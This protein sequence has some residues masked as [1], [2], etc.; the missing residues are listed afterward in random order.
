MALKQ[1]KYVIKTVQHLWGFVLQ[2]VI[3]T[4][5]EPANVFVLITAYGIARKYTVLWRGMKGQRRQLVI[6]CPHTVC[7]TCTLNEHS[8]VSRKI[9]TPAFCRSLLTLPDSLWSFTSTSEFE[10][11]VVIFH[12]LKFSH[13][14]PSLHEAL[15]HVCSEGFPL[16]H[17]TNGWK[18]QYLTLI[19]FFKWTNYLQGPNL[20]IIF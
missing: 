15:L 13:G 4:K 1:P 6:L 8:G 12:H 20:S 9:L 7:F 18:R 2:F 16:L 11:W 3:T 19:I 14:L 5:G 17:G 10:P